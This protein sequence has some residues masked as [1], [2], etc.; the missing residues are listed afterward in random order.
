MLPVAVLQPTVGLK[1]NTQ[2]EQ[3]RAYRVHIGYTRRGA[4]RW[5]YFQTLEAASKACNAVFQQTGI[6][7]TVE[8]V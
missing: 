5:R 6:I 4:D 3:T 1:M 8:R 2:I 7:L